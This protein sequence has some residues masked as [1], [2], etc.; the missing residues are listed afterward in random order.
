MK[1]K[2]SYRID[3]KVIIKLSIIIENFLHWFKS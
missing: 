1:W 3:K 2:H